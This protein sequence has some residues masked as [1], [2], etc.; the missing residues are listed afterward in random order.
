MRRNRVANSVG[1]ADSA[2]AAVSDSTTTI[3]MTRSSTPML[4]P[5]GMT[6][7][8]VGLAVSARANGPLIAGGDGFTNL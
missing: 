7:R 4:Q 1:L 3:V 2:T 5:S 8:G 6:R